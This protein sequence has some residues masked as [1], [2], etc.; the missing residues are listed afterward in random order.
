M[1]ELVYCRDEA[2]NHQLPIAAA[3]CIIQIVSTE[4]C[5]SLMRNLMQIHCSTRSVILHVMTT[6]H[7]CSLNG[8]YYPHLSST[9]KSSLFT[10][11]HSSP[12]S[13]AASSHQC[14]ANHS[15]YINNGWTFSRQA[16]YN[17]LYTVLVLEQEKNI[18]GKTH[19]ILIK[20]VVECIVLYH[21]QSLSFDKCTMVM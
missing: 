21:C 9:V 18:H 17:V 8:V 19:E 4:E 14:Q 6:Q 10:H 11:V 20:P 1:H 5:S 2:A 3:F 12:L 7:T 16:L 15:R 13:L